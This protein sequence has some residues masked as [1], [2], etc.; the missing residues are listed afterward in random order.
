MFGWIQS[1]L[2]RITGSGG[3][4]IVTTQHC[5]E[6][7]VWLTDSIGE[8]KKKILNTGD[9]AVRQI[10]SAAYKFDVENDH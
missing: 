9:F 1:S 7:F 3:K 6:Q 5:S 10:L 4:K 8:E 2:L